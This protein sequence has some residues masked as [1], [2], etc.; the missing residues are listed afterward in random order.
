MPTRLPSTLSS[1][2]VPS[3]DLRRVQPRRQGQQRQRLQRAR[4]VVAPVR[5]A[6]GQH[7]ARPASATSQPDAASPAGSGG[8]VVGDDQ[9]AGVQVARRRRC[10]RRARCPCGG[11]PAQGA[12]GVGA[13]GSAVGRAAPRRP[14]SPGRTRAPRAPGAAASSRAARPPS[15]H[16]AQVRR[17][18][19]HGAPRAPSGRGRTFATIGSQSVLAAGEARAPA[20]SVP[21]R[22]SPRPRRRDGGA[23]SMHPPGRA[24]QRRGRVPP[25]RRSSCAERG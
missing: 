2:V 22:A 1:S 19:W 15:P 18:P 17:A 20:V 12:V 25:E 14:R 7:L 6:G 3:H 9:P 5:V 16:A 23:G 10:G 11:R 8:R 13:R 4:R 24:P 21:H